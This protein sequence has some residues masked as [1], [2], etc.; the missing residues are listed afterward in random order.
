MKNLKALR[1]LSVGNNKLESIPFSLGYLESLR[2]LRLAGNPLGED[3][4][5][6]VDGNDGSPSPLLVPLAESEKE[7]RLTIK[8]KQYLKHE[9]AALESGGESRFTTKQT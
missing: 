6:I 1:V 8:I 9:A 2:V 3:L 5:G 7:A 4:K